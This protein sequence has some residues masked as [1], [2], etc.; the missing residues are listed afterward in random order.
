VIPLKKKNV[1]CEQ[2]YLEWR[3]CQGY[4]EAE[5]RLL[6]NNLDG[7]R[8][9]LNEPSVYL[10]TLSKY[11][12]RFSM[13]FQTISKATMGVFKRYP[14]SADTYIKHLARLTTIANLLGTG[15]YDASTVLLRS[16]IEAFLRSNLLFVHDLE[17]RGLIPE[18][19]GIDGWES[20]VS[21]DPKDAMALGQLCKVMSNLNFNG[22][23]KSPY[24]FMKIWYLNEVTHSNI[25]IIEAGD[26]NVM[27][28][29]SI[30]KEFDEVK[31]DEF[32]T[33]LLR[34][35]EFQIVFW[36]SLIDAFDPQIKPVIM[37]SIET[38]A[39]DTTFPEYQSVLE[40]RF[41][42]EF[43]E[44]FRLAGILGWGEKVLPTMKELIAGK[45]NSG[46]PEGW[47]QPEF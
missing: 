8:D 19:I 24:Q 10:E 27:T 44:L 31:C 17:Q 34:F 2:K 47:W 13:G 41:V 45:T 7:F 26:D 33:V 20:A 39:D 40:G 1:S 15:Y 28:K 36:Q 25:D 22:K 4:T 46:F 6:L 5:A 35:V 9:E 21:D 42:E 16:S 32:A 11:T 14:D 38:P 12:V 37:L 3:M 23:I 43:E 18:I 30:R 29:Q